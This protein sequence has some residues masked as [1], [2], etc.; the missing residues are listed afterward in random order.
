MTIAAWGEP[1]AAERLSG[2]ATEV[3]NELIS[4]YRR[5]AISPKGFRDMLVSLVDLDVRSVLPTLSTPTLVLHKPADPVVSVG[6]SR[7]VTARIPSARLVELPGASHLIADDDTYTLVDGIITFVTAFRL[8]S[9]TN[10]CWRLC[11][12]QTWSHQPIPRT[13]VATTAGS[14]FS[15]IM[16]SSSGG[17]WSVIADD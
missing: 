11:C 13:P 4:R 5:M 17:S 10:E 9:P 8:P 7:Y 6:Q 2:D 16:A 12:S 15:M 3:D 14:M 1:R